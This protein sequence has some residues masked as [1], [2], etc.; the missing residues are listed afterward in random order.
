MVLVNWTKQQTKERKEKRST[1]N[2]IKQ[3]NQEESLRAV[4]YTTARNK[5]KRKR[6]STSP[7]QSVVT[8]GKKKSV[9][10][11]EKWLMNEKGGSV[12]VLE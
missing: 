3:R 11:D 10:G 1:E 8:G 12:G 7:T 4:S 6:E 5:Q 2:G 9:D